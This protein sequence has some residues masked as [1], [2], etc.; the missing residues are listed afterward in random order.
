MNED[1]DVKSNLLLL[2]KQAMA[3]QNGTPFRSALNCL[4]NEKID[5]ILK[6]NHNRSL[7]K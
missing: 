1:K 6:N 7:S 5:E 2:F 4:Q 3:S